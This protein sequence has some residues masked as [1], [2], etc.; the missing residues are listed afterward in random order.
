MSTT[1]KFYIRTPKKLNKN[2]RYP[3]YIRVVHNRKK[4][5]GKTSLTPIVGTELSRWIEV[6][7]RFSSKEQ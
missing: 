1:L 2:K 6:S 4:A 7:Q 5:E 3:I